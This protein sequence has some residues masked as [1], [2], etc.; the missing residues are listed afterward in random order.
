MAHE[1]EHKRVNSN[2]KRRLKAFHGTN[3]VSLCGG[4]KPTTATPWWGDAI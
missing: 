2:T 4:R 3:S 1:F